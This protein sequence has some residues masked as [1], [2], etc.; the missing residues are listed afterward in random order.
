MKGF[1]HFVALSISFIGAV[2]IGFFMG[3]GYAEV[4]TPL[5]R[6][7]L[8]ASE[9]VYDTYGPLTETQYVVRINPVIKNDVLVLINV[10]VRPSTP[11]S[12]RQDILEMYSHIDTD[13]VITNTLVEEANASSTRNK[14]ISHKRRLDSAKHGELEEGSHE[15][16][17][18]GSL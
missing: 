3:V 13:V 5:C 18:G 1:L 12:V 9:A 6:S 17:N 7:P 2:L 4:T 15:D 11:G 8:H 16:S 10:E 14:N